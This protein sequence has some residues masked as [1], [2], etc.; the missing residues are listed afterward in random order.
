M[1]VNFSPIFTR[2]ENV[3]KRISDLEKKFKGLT[4]IVERA[5]KVLDKEKEE[6]EVD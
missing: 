3:E 4:E 6:K 2:I 1:E 5:L